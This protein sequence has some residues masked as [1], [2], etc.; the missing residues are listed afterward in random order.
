ME[1]DELELEQV[2]YREFLRGL[3]E[4]QDEELVVVENEGGKNN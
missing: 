2:E 1:L 4:K 3:D